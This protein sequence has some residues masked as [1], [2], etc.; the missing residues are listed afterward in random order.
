M[1]RPLVAGYDDMTDELDDNWVCVRMGYT[2][3]DMVILIG[4]QF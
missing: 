2:P 1:A 4:T 3:A